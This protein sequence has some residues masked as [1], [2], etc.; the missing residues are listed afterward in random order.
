MADVKH[1]FLAGQNDSHQ[2]FLVLAAQNIDPYT[3]EQVVNGNVLNAAQLIRNGKTSVD[4]VYM[5]L[6]FHISYNRRRVWFDRS[7]FHTVRKDTVNNIRDGLKDIVS[8]LTGPTNE[9]ENEEI[10]ASVQR[11][12]GGKTTTKQ[13][14]NKQEAATTQSE[15]AKT[16]TTPMTAE[17]TGTADGTSAE[18]PKPKKERVVKA[19][20]EAVGVVDCPTCQAVKG[21][22]CYGPLKEGM[23][24]ED[25]KVVWLPHAT[26]VKAAQAV[27][28]PEAYEAEQAQKAKLL[29]ERAAKRKAKAVKPPADGETKGATE[30]VN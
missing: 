6:V 18:T 25:R 29:E 7:N 4:E 9:E 13:E 23:K 17:N 21:H 26:R 15:T 11:S 22:N 12:T 16:A 28:N 5:V 3:V 2:S 1:T 30:A 8:G 20:H 10:M 24:P 27:L 19:P 14:A